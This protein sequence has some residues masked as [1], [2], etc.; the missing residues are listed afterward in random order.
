MHIRCDV[1][2]VGFG[3]VGMVLAGLLGKRGIR[4]I[5][6]EK[7]LDVFPLPRAAHIDHTGLRTLQEIGCLDE[8]LPRM[9]SNRGLELVNADLQPLI[10][11]PGDQGSVSSLPASMYF[12]QPDFDRTLDRVVSA[13][14]TVDV[15]RGIEMIS[16]ADDADAVVAQCVDRRSGEELHI[17]ADWLVGCDGA[18]SPVRESAGI[19]LDSLGFDEQWLVLDLIDPSRR[20]HVLDR[21]I[22]V[23]DPR[24]PHVANPIPGGRYRAEFMLLPGDDPERLQQPASIE[25][26]LRPLF[27]DIRFDIE[28]SAAYTFHGL[29]AEAWRERRV[30]VA[31]DAAHQMPPFLGQGMCSGLRDASNL[32]WKLARVVRGSVP[33]ALLDTYEQER[34]PHVRAIVSS[35]V[36]FGR[37]VSTRDPQQAAQRDRRLLA[38]DDTTALTFNLP[39]L[40]ASRLVHQSGGALFPQPILEDG[41]RLD[42]KVGDRFLV[43]ARTREQLESLCATWQSFDGIEALTLNTSR[44]VRNRLASWLDRRDADIVFVRP[45]RY[46]MATGRNLREITAAVPTLL[47]SPNSTSKTSDT[48]ASHHPDAPQYGSRFRGRQ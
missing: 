41:V 7:D 29:V 39:P 22:Q 33:D 23:C 48:Q 28:R 31:G 3:P 38:G 32:A 13:M 20:E 26:L 17:R 14:H 34:A 44:A 30:L 15:R 5:V 35:A 18:D 40:P 8:M 25:K 43:V 11:L 1:A 27:P 37:F 4:V 12:Y 24:R 47:P 6:V 21:A 46:V 42:D 19:S 2:I 45:D 10:R 36:E 9:L 16:L